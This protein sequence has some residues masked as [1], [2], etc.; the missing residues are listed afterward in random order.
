MEQTHALRRTVREVSLRHGFAYAD[1]TDVV[2]DYM[3]SSGS[4]FSPFALYFDHVHLSPAGNRLL[5][6]EIHEALH[7][8]GMEA[9]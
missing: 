9:L 5:A 3:R 8:A 2:S 7:K 4:S 6:R 1:Y